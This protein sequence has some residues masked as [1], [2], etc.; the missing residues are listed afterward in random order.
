MA[1]QMGDLPKV[2]LHDHLI[3]GLRASTFIELAD[4]TGYRRLPT[5]DP[6][7]LESW[8]R[9]AGAGDLSKLLWVLDH[10]VAVTQTQEALERMAFEAVEDLAND[11]VIYAEVRI[12]PGPNAG[13]RSRLR[14]GAAAIRMPWWTLRV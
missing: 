13:R 11:G 1:T 12:A 5:S 9:S 3:G 10:G 7:Q 14:N 2:V 6:V 4:D 8:I